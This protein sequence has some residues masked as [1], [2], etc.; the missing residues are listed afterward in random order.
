VNTAHAATRRDKVRTELVDVEVAGGGA[1]VKSVGWR[2]VSAGGLAGARGAK[3]TV[4]D[5]GADGLL[6]A[7]DEHRRR[8]ERARCGHC[9]EAG[10]P[11][12]TPMGS[13]AEA[14]DPDRKDRKRQP[15]TAGNGGV[16]AVAGCLSGPFPRVRP[17]INLVILV[18]IHHWSQRLDLSLAPSLWSELATGQTQVGQR[19]TRHIGEAHGGRAPNMVFI[20]S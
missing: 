5:E 12:V 14:G 20:C 8:H 4:D 17:F 2:G 7:F 16:I 13:K 15:S 1:D 10:A 18:P 11:P 6:E 19:P 3:R 9:L